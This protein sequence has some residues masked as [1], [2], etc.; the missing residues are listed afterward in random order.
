[1]VDHLAEVSYSQSLKSA[2]KYCLSNLDLSQLITGILWCWVSA[3]FKDHLFENCEEW[4]IT[5]KE[6][7]WTTGKLHQL[8][9]TQEYRSDVISVFGVESG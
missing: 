4:H 7:T 8:F 5:N 3:L 2:A 1:M 9:L 6:F